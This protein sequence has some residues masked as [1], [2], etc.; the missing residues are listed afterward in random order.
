MQKSTILLFVAFMLFESPDSVL[1]AQTFAPKVDYVVGPRPYTLVSGDFDAD[2]DF[3]LA[4]TRSGAF[5]SD[6]IDSVCILMN[7]GDGTFALPSKYSVG[8]FPSLTNA[9]LDKDGDIDLAA[10]D[11]FTNTIYILLNN[12]A[13][14]FLLASS[15]ASGG[16]NP[17]KLCASDLDGDGDFDLAVP[18]SGSSNISVF[19]NNGNA[20]FVSPLLYTTG[21]RP[22]AA[23]SADLDKDGDYDLVVTNNGSASVAV[24]LNNGKGIFAQRV[25]YPVGLFAQSLSLADYNGDGC[26]DLAVPNAGP[27]TPYVSVLIGNCDGTFKPKVDWTGC[28][29]HTVASAD[30]DLDGDIDMAVTNNECNS[31]SVFLNGGNGTFTLHST[32]P[33]GIGT[34]HIVAKDFNGDGKID[35]AAS[36]FDNNG[37]P[38]NTIS[39]FLNHSITSMSEELGFAKTYSLDQNYPNPFN[40][41][42]T[43]QYALPH[44]GFVTL[45][46][47]NMLGEQTATLVQENISAGIH[48]VEWNADDLPSDVYFYRL[49]AGTFIQTKKLILLK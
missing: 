26:L 30:Y 2:G 10:A 36:N 35:L 27:A 15:F 21:T 34:Q 19:M 8:D 18:N 5:E 16:I 3:D 42:T 31:V 17:H 40:P 7:N 46:I 43:I 25:D 37:V 20:T 47:F 9:D 48:R 32:L 44:S 12:G 4:T 23:I 39:V 29:P 22:H 33:A 13:G 41:R 38:G 24:M 14:V 45:R 6:G 49:Q 28:R 1:L 11:Y